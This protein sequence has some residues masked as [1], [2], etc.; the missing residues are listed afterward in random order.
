MA[1]SCHARQGPGLWE[2][3]WGSGLHCSLT[4]STRV[5]TDTAPL[6]EPLVSP[7]VIAVPCRHLYT[8][9]DPLYVCAMGTALTFTGPQTPC[10]PL[11]YA[12]LSPHIYV[13]TPGPSAHPTM[14]PPLP[15]P[16]CMCPA[17]IHTHTHPAA[18][19]APCAPRPHPLPP[20]RARR[21]RT[22]SR[23]A[24]PGANPPGLPQA[25][26]SPDDSLDVR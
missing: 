19:P 11:L 13:C 14:H 25:R 3:V 9:T 16:P 26:P 15:A 7:A 5:W 4:L 23:R 10:T 12:P 24:S 22:G 8:Y 1:S 2:P 6:R 17:H 18:H 20:P 21:P